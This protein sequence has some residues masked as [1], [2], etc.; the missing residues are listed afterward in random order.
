VISS[1]FP[2]LPRHGVALV[3]LLAFLAT[4]VIALIAIERGHRRVA[5]VTKPLTTALLLAVVGAPRGTFSGLVWAGIIASTAGDAAL[6]IEGNAPFMVG[7]GCFLAAHVTYVVAFAR[8][9]VWSAASWVGLALV[10]VATPA[11]LRALWPGAAGLRG[12]VVVYAAALSAMVVAAFSTVGSALPG[13]PLAA[14]GAVLFYVS[15]ASLAVNRFV[16][17][18]RYGT[19][20]SVGVYWLGQLGIALATRAQMR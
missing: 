6:V 8:A 10:A 17:P 15:D 14:I 3:A 19:L 16:R 13:A 20:L 1:W 9:G 4:G 2:E 11:L 12:P 18:L 5:L 7:L